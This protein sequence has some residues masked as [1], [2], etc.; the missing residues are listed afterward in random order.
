MG[1]VEIAEEM[2][3]LSKH[4]VEIGILA[5]DRE[6]KGKDNKATILEYAIWNEYGTKHIPPR[7]FM[8]HA[9]D[10]NQD[11]I[12]KLINGKLQEVLAGSI[13]GRVALMQIGETIRGMII[14]SIASAS[15]WAK[16][17]KTSTLKQKLKNEQE[18]NDKPLIDNRFLIK[19]IRWQ[20]L[21]NG[22]VIYVSDF[23][24]V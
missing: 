24:E 3:Y 9:I 15:S 8:Q 4:R 19:A 14:A 23:A 6:R 13:T 20:L 7:P 2:E 11:M 10:S 12:K 22:R 1:I 5:I 16:P 17:N 21:E 18:N